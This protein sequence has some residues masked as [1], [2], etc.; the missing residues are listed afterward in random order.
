MVRVSVIVPV[1][2]EERY[3]KQC[4]DSL[5]GQTLE[6]MEIICVDDGSTDS[7]P[8]ILAE[9][10]RKDSRI[11]VLTQKNRFAGEAR[12][13]EICGRGVSVFFGCR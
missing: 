6:E 2:N 5:R 9:Y 10:A 7:S 11:K 3:L 8:Q 13:H 12:N 4:L 1:Y